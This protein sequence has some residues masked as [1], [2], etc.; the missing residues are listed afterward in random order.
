MGRADRLRPGGTSVIVKAPRFFTVRQKIEAIQ[1]E[2][3]LR[4]HVYPNRVATGR[5]TQA[6]ADY[7]IAIF[8]AILDDYKQLSHD[9]R[10][11]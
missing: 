9:E 10:L 1:R 7:Q 4:S 6:L 5:M 8:D 3:S 2:L 11:L